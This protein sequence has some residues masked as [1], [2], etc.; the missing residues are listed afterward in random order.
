LYKDAAVLQRAYDDDLG[1]TAAFNLN[2]LR[3]LNRV[4]GANFN[5]RQWQHVA[6]FNEAQSRIEMHLQARVAQTV[7]WPGGQRAFAA[8]ERIHTEN[9]YKWRR[10]DFEALLREA[11]FTRVQSWVDDK[12]WFAVMLAQAG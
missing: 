11:G 3:H 5:L 6:L 10:S 7:L 2:L 12:G 4:L 9:S 8:G 1:V